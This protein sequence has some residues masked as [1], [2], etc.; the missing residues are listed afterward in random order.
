MRNAVVAAMPEAV[1]TQAVVDALARKGFAWVPDGKG[2]GKL[3]RIPKAK[4]HGK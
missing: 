4:P 1:K 3:V 2:G